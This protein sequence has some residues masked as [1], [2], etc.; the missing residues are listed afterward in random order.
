MARPFSF[1]RPALAVAL[2][3]GAANAEPVDLELVLAVDTSRSMDFEELVLQREGYAAALE[4]PA[5]STAL[6]MGPLGRAAIMYFEWGGP[7]R[8]RVLVDW[9]IVEGPEDAAAIAAKLRE[10]PIRGLRGTSISGAMEAAAEAL[11]T[12]AYHGTRRVIDISGDGPNNRGRPVAEVRDE[13]AAKG[14]EIN[15]LPFMVKEPGGAYS[16]PDLDIYYETCVIAGESA[17]VI[18]I[19]EM[20]RLVAS[21][22]QKL[23]LEISGQPGPP[24]TRLRPATAADDCL[25]GEKLR[26]RLNLP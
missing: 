10:A 3:T 4:H 25:I 2:L 26:R 7:G 6:N 21:I 16:I 15:G 20:S 22:R 1:L 23:V 5:V 14:I 17:F 9:T 18:P 8:T 19:F 12:N 24:N 13:V 11:E